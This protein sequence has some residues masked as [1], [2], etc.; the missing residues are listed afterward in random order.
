MWGV[1]DKC[2]IKWVMLTCTTHQGAPQL[3][4]PE[5][6]PTELMSCCHCISSLLCRD[7]Y[8]C[9]QRHHDARSLWAKH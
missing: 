3:L 6:L 8:I 2:E 4:P 7:G 1:L 5:A 9:L